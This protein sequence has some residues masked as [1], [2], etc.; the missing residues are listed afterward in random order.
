MAILGVL[1]LARFFKIYRTT[2]QD[3]GKHPTSK[4]V[5]EGGFTAKTQEFPPSTNQETSYT[6]DDEMGKKGDAGL[7][8]L[9]DRYPK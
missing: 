6:V 2:K 7:G 8:S 5:N 3:P 1:Y 9:E 4:G